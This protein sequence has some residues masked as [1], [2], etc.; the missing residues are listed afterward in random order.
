MQKAAKGSTGVV[1]ESWVPE[2]HLRARK[3]KAGGYTSATSGDESE[4][5]PRRRSARK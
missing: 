4:G 1:D 5:T 3:A 2:H